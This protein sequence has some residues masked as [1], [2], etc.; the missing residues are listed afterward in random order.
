MQGLHHEGAFR[1][2]QEEAIHML[3]KLESKMVVFK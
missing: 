3:E 2:V 1:G